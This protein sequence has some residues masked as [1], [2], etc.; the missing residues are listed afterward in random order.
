MT[1]YD[2]FHSSKLQFLHLEARE[3]QVSVHKRELLAGS[4]DAIAPGEHSCLPHLPADQATVVPPPTPPLS[5][6]KNLSDAKKH[7]ESV[8][9]LRDL[10]RMLMDIQ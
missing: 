5:A 1:G 8:F 3:L 4:G 7:K 6:V 2:T 9:P 10:F